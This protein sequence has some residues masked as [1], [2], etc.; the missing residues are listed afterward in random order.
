MCSCL[1]YDFSSYFIVNDNNDIFKI[2][3][4]IHVDVTCCLCFISVYYTS[5]RYFIK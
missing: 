4:L 5:I 2:F 3:L 1:N